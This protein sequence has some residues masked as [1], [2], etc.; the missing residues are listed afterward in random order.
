MTLKEGRQGCVKVGEG[1]MPTLVGT[2]APA[3]DPG[4]PTY[5]QETVKTEVT[6]LT[7]LPPQ[8]KR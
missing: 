2:A 4:V 7:T 6:S 8:R 3:V 5:S 1:K